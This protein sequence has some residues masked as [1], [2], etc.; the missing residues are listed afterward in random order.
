VDRVV[1]QLQRAGKRM[2]WR[3]TYWM[4]QCPAHPDAEPSLSIRE[5]ER[6]E[7]LL[8]C[9]AGCDTR[10]VSRYLGMEMGELFAEAV[11]SG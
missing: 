11:G 9:F 8:Y 6:G 1:D 10:E 3:G 2:E 5:G 7:A 4:A